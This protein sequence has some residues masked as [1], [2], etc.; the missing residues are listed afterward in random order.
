M[1]ERSPAWLTRAGALVATVLVT[2]AITPM[3][4]AAGT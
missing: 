1:I 4:R 3:A 2:A